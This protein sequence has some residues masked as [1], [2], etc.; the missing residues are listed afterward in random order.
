MTMR[1]EKDILREFA[2]DIAE[3]ISRKTISALQKIT[4]TLSGEDSELNNAWDEICVQV[5]S[6][7]SFFWDAYDE[8]VQ[9]FVSAYVEE[10]KPHEK[11]ALWFQTEQGWDWL[12]EPEEEREENPPVLM[13]DITQYIVHEYVYVKAGSWTNERIRAYTDRQYL[14]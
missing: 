2:R 11:S 7:Q 12:Y 13:E 14:D 8:T 1:T 9:S 10:L 3:R 6:E 4:D 5:Q